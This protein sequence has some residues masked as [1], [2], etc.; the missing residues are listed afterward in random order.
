MTHNGIPR[1]ARQMSMMV[2]RMN[3]RMRREAMTL[4][5]RY[6]YAMGC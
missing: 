1:R 6:V 5:K 4:M 2:P 3:L